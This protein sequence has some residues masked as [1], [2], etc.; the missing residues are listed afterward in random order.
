LVDT[1]TILKKANLKVTPLR[2]DVLEVIYSSSSAVGNEDLEAALYD[3]DRITLYRTLKSF[4][5]KGLIHKINALDGQSMYAQCHNCIEHH[6]HK[7]DSHLHFQCTSCNKT[8]CIENV[9]IPT[10]T[11][12][13]YAIADQNITLSGLCKVCNEK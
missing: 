12:P 2:K 7:H 10:F 5:E 8:F 13:G 9:Q 1:T 3:F 11:L 6:A 4:E